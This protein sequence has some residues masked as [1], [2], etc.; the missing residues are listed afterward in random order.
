[1][2]LNSLETVSPWRARLS[3]LEHKGWSGIERGCSFSIR[4]N[5][6]VLSVSILKSLTSLVQPRTMIVFKQHRMS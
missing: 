5:A 6:P 1:V 3:M 2:I 4:E